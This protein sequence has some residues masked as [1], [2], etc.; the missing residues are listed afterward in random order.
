MDASDDEIFALTTKDG[1]FAV[2]RTVRDVFFVI[3]CAWEP[4][5]CAAADGRPPSLACRRRRT[6]TRPARSLMA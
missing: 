6:W 1:A 5:P 3:R 4:A 2:N